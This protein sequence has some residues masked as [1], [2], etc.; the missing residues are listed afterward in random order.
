M[1]MVVKETK[2]GRGKVWCDNEGKKQ[3]EKRDVE[4]KIDIKLME[5]KRR[6]EKRLK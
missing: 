3:G 5:E 2:G 1:R 6:N 4:R